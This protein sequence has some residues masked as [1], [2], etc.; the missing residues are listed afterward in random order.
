MNIGKVK[1]GNIP[2]IAAVIMD[3]EDKKAIAQAKRN[4]AD[5]LELR[6]DCFKR[7]D[8]AYVQKILKDIQTKDIPIIATI[9]SKAEG[10]NTDIED[11][12]RLALFEDI[13]PLVNAVDIEL[14]SKKILKDVINKAHKSHKKVII[15]YHNF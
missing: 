9:R 4:G 1:L 7:Q 13:I 15:S 5:L 10:G 14:G 8:A 3:G 2:R 6:I 12:E 11:R